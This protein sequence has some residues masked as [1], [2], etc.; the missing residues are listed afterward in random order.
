MRITH[1]HLENWRN[2]RRVDV[3]LAGRVF[4][5]GP[6][7]AGKSN[8]L[9]AIRFLRDIAEPRGGF[10]AAV[11]DWRGGVSKIRSLHA[12]K[13]PN[14]VLEVKLL[15]EKIEW[16]YRLEF[17]QDN[18]RR[19]VVR[20]ETAWKQGKIVLD[21]PDKEDGTD[22]ELLGETSLEH[23]RSNVEFRPISEFLGQ[24]RYLHLVPQLVREPERSVGRTRDP[25]GGDFL[26]Q[27]AALQK[28]NARVFKGRL[29]RIND[30][31]RVAVPQ[32][33][34]LKLERDIKGI[35]HLQG[36]FEHWRPDAGWQ[37]ES[38]FS[39]G[40]LRLLG[41]LW[42]ILDGSAPL[43]LEE[44]ELSLHPAIVRVL[45]GVFSKLGD[46]AERQL[47]V[48]THSEQLLADP[49]VGLEEVLLLQPT[50]DGTEVLPASKHAQIKALLEGGMPLSEAV[51]PAV[52]PRDVQQLT[53]AFEE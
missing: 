10:Q 22:P 43:L 20:A 28:N 46:K 49:G 35:P 5:V 47:F 40:T 6:N 41:L 8:L 3:D 48:S 23:S 25:Y 36:L 12:R 7:A 29:K 27:L 30:A 37:T 31:L 4:V 11:G 38:Q 15:I 33:T 45:P 13:N 21:R 19:P 42:A 50:S 9:D 44:P 16:R 1:L 53:I 26:E 32:L 14:V 52:A 39:D 17:G 24:I 2:F 34:E 18:L 51:M